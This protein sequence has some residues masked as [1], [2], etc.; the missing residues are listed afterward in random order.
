MKD[1]THCPHCH[2]PLLNEHVYIRHLGD[3][4]KKSCSLKIDHRLYINTLSKS[5]ELLEICITINMS[6]GT[7]A[8]WNFTK[9]T[10]WILNPRREVSTKID[11][12]F[13]EPDMS[14]Y[15]KL[16]TKL[17]SYVLFS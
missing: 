14:N 16:V 3:V 2:E 11:I 5:D 1:L 17:K 6:D 8:Y 13:F 4:T 7:M 9:S 10:L 12:P 15:K